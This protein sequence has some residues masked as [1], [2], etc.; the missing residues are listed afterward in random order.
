[1]C[2]LTYKAPVVAWTRFRASM[3]RVVDPAAAVGFTHVEIS[4]IRRTRYAVGASLLLRLHAVSALST[5][6]MRQL[7]GDRRHC[8]QPNGF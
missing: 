8:Y 2:R 7:F 6:G 4:P 3:M 1:M 5:R